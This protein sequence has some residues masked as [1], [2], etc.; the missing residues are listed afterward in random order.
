MLYVQSTQYIATYIVHEI[1]KLC[2]VLFTYV[3]VTPSCTGSVPV[4]M[5]NIP[6]YETVH[7]PPVSDKV[8]MEPNPAYQVLTSDQV[9]MESNP[10]YQVSTGDHV[11]MESNPA[12]QKLSSRSGTADVSKQK[13]AGSVNYYEDIIND[14]NIPM[15]ENPSYAIP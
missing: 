9:K 6:V 10:A 1:H 3:C 14:Q 11:K 5:T 7:D 15:T 4:A 13:P 8:K 2:K 12:Y